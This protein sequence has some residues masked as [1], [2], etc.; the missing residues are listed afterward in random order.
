[1]GLSDAGTY[2]VY[3]SNYWGQSTSPGQDTLQVFEP[4]VDITS[5]NLPN[6]SIQIQLLPTSYSGTLTVSL[7]GGSGNHQ[8]YSTTVSGGSHSISFG[9]L[10]S[11]PQDQYTQI[12][13]SWAVT[14]SPSDSYN[15]GFR[16][17]GT[18]RHSQY[19]SPSESA[20]SAGTSSYNITNNQCSYSSGTL[21]TSFRNAVNLNGSG[22]SISYNDV[23]KEALCLNPQYSPPAG[24]IDNTFREN[25]TIVGTY[26]SVGNTTVAVNPSHPYIGAN[27][28]VYIDTVG[29]KSVTDECPGCVTAQ[30]DNY[31]TTTACSGINDLGNFATF[32]LN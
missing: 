7:I 27:D 28:S 16:A 31:T 20:C 9:T 2:V 23:A 11:I 22:H 3:C 30:L 14:T 8:V 19:N 12:Q 6:N 1:M 15:Y 26:G 10:S 5:A 25:H 4:S 32:L 21:R 17:L 18:Y 13:A 29:T 24:A